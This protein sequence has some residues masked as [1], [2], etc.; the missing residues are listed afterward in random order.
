MYNRYHQPCSVVQTFSELLKLGLMM[1]PFCSP[2]IFSW[3][4]G[5]ELV[6]QE[7][8]TESLELDSQTYLLE[9]SWLWQEAVGGAGGENH[10][11]LSQLPS[12]SLSPPSLLLALL[13]LGGREGVKLTS[14]VV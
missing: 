7:W 6:Y 2:H 9:D 8:V 11:I 12:L 3:L 14:V 5:M 13:K 1:S 10:Q 4:P